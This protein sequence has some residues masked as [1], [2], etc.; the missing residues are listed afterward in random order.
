MRIVDVHTSR[1][2]QVKIQRGLLART[3][4]EML[5]LLGKPCKVAVLTDETVNGLY[6]ARVLESLAQSGFQACAFA[7]P[8]GETNKNLNQWGNML[9]FLAES[10]LTR[11]DCVLAFG[12]GVPGDMAGFAAACY[13]RGIP[14]VQAPTT[15]LAM[16]DS[17]VGGKTGVDLPS[18]KNLAGAFCQP[19]LVICDPDALTTL[20]YDTLLDGV[21]ESVKH[22]ILADAAL[23]ELFENGGWQDALETI[24]ERDVRIKAAFVTGDERDTGKRQQLNLGHTFGHA[25]ERRSE[26]RM[27]HGHAVGIGMVY[28][29]RLACRL[30]QCDEETLRRVAE[31]LTAV[32]LATD[33]PYTPEELAEIALL[34]KKRMGETL[35]MVLPEEIG[36]CQLVPVDV[37]RLPEWFRM[38][39]VP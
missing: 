34:D 5:A 9:S 36:R 7:I 27:S 23:F 21:A 39:M 20:P 19:S 8:P 11:S 13:L 4:Q 35:T 32:G 30:G 25:L 6:G 14:F 28:A 18:G 33:A 29:A 24:V 31:T 3:G 17:S 16:A 12:G 10:G 37:G 1:P 22:G 38:A 15:L 2:Y 26:Y